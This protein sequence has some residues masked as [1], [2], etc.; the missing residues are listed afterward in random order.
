MNQQFQH[1]YRE[2]TV[3][4]G[5]DSQVISSMRRQGQDKFIRTQPRLRLFRKIDEGTGASYIRMLRQL[6][7]LPVA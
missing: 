5:D 3:V 1:E 7:S 6:M 2:A 4:N